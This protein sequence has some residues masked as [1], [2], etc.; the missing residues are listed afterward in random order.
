MR[1]AF[2]AEGAKYDF[3]GTIEN[4]TF[5][6]YGTINYKGKTYY[7]AQALPFVYVGLDEERLEK[8]FDKETFRWKW[9]L[10]TTVKKKRKKKYVEAAYTLPK[11]VNPVCDH[12]TFVLIDITRVSI[13]NFPG[14]IRRA[15]SIIIA[16][17]DDGYCIK[18]T[19]GKR[20]N[21]IKVKKNGE[22][23]I[24]KSYAL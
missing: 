17:A 3:E 1:I 16:L 22:V 24:E 13:E 18:K 15:P 10:R 21:Y 9:R 12:E 14:I 7:V 8:L 4:G 20:V 11:K 2:E 5:K 23:I 19:S 6:G